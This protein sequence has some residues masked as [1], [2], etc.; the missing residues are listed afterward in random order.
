MPGTLRRRVQA[1]GRT[2]LAFLALSAG[3]AGAQTVSSPEPR[4]AAAQRSLYVDVDRFNPSGGPWDALPLLGREARTRGLRLAS[5]APDPIAC[6]LALDGSGAVD[7]EPKT[8]AATPPCLD[9]FACEFH[10]LPLSGGP[11]GLVVLDWEPTRAK[12][13]SLFDLSGYWSDFRGQF[14][15]FDPIAILLVSDRPLRPK[16]PEWEQAQ[17]RMAFLL[18]ALIRPINATEA[19]YLSPPFRNVT[20][21]ELEAGVD[22]V[23]AKLRLKT[24]R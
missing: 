11:Y 4:A 8:L 14:D 23:G 13:Q 6:V 10:D 24:F 5:E 22:L 15:S 3:A 20:P 18:K 21:V 19:Q 16:S 7:C 12:P 2:A 17:E 9:R 1:L